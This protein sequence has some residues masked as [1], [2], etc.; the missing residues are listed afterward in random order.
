MRTFE[1]PHPWLEEGVAQFMASV[2]TEHQDGRETAITQ[3]DNMRGAL[4]LAEPADP[5]SRRG[6]AAGDGA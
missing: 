1:S 5:G 4:S 2:W 6:A 3:M